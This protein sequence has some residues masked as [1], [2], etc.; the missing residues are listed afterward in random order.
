[1]VIFENI[2]KFLANYW[3]AFIAISSLIAMI[4]LGMISFRVQM[5]NYQKNLTRLIKRDNRRFK[6]KVLG[7]GIKSDSIIFKSYIRA[8]MIFILNDE[9]ENVK[10]Q[11]YYVSF[12]NYKLI[13]LIFRSINHH[14]KKFNYILK[15]IKKYRITLKNIEINKKSKLPESFELYPD[16]PENKNLVT[17]GNKAYYLNSIYD[18]EGNLMVQNQ[19]T[20]ETIW[21]QYKFFLNHDRD[22]MIITVVIKT[23]K[24]KDVSHLAT[25]DQKIFFSVNT[26]EKKRTIKATFKNMRKYNYL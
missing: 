9:G 12:R 24:I 19:V 8:K 21:G 3:E 7:T 15:L 1:M 17:T 25:K 11:N 4:T 22:D 18:A 20:E 2:W 23:N 16:L 26:A 10:S 13:K 5:K 6:K 14:L